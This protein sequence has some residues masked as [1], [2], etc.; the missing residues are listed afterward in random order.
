MSRWLQ[1]LDGMETEKNGVLAKIWKYKNNLK[2]NFIWKYKN[3][4]AW[5][6]VSS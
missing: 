3:Y 6:A 2:N 5:L 4:T 1:L